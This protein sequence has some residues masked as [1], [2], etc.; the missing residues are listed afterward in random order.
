MQQHS[1]RSHTHL[2]ALIGAALV[3]TC[4]TLFQA[5]AGSSEQESADPAS[6]DATAEPSSDDWAERLIGTRDRTHLADIS[7]VRC[8][9]CHQAVAEEWRQSLHALA[10]VDPHYQS[11]LKKVRRKKS[12][13]G[14]HAPQSMP[15]QEWA[16]KPKVRANDRHHGI[17]CV[18]C[19]LGADGETVLGPYGLETEAHPT[20]KSDAF[21]PEGSASRACVAC[22]ATTIGPV[23]GI[24]KDFVDTEQTELGLSC[25][26]CHMPALRRPIANAEDGTPLEVRRAHSHRLETPRDPEFL[27][28]AFDIKLKALPEG[29]ELRFENTTG[30]RVPGLRDRLITFKATIYEADGDVAGEAELAFDHRTFLPVEEATVLE[31]RGKGVRL[32]LVGL[33]RPP[34]LKRAGK[35]LEETF[36][37]AQ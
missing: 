8:V 11:E 7:G 28:S 26:G 5:S 20:E 10:W 6:S 27:R 36:E 13:W 1:G 35:F 34:G 23:I 19:H 33:H 9:E 3:V 21:D 17:D 16:Q 18:S 22:H 2:L 15:H 12:C 32:E 31:V 25:V 14:C 37:L 30:H 4:C 29:A 24:A